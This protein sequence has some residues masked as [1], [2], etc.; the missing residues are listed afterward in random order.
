MVT[1]NTSTPESEVLLTEFLG[2]ILP[3]LGISQNSILRRPF[4]W[5]VHVPLLRCC[6]LLTDTD[7]I[8]ANSGF[9]DGARYLATH[10]FARD[11]R[12]RGSQNVP[13]N[14]PLLVVSN[15]PGGIDSPSISTSLGRHDLKIIASD[16]HLLKRLPEISRH[17]IFIGDD[18]NVRMGAIRESIRHLQ[19][20]GALLIFPTGLI[21]PDPGFMKHSS[22]VMENWS[23]SIEIF[24]RKVPKTLLLPAVVSD[25]LAPAAVNHPVVRIQK[26][27]WKRQRLAEF[28]QFIFQLIFLNRLR[29]EPKISFGQPVGLE[30]LEAESNS[31]RLKESIIAQERAL[32]ED[33]LRAFYPAG[34]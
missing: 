9:I 24:L 21:D 11:I 23:D 6:R 32:L 14:G 15:H 5:L 22:E 20:G 10:I 29:L 30:T 4:G 34:N 12:V 7:R 1:I 31:R 18:I 2:D 33:H 16:V 19:N 17:L 25:V 3:I 13:L 27:R 26:E 28:F 8:I